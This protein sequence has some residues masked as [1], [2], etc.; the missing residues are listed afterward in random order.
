MRYL[1][2]SGSLS[3]LGG[4]A[5]VR[6]A[7]NGIK[8]LDKKAEFAS[9]HRKRAHKEGICK[10]FIR[11]SQNEEAFKW[12]NVTLDVGGLCNNQR[13]K[14]VWMNLS[15]KYRKPLVYMS[16]SFNKADSK[17][18]KGSKILARGKRSA[19]EV[20]KTGCKAIIA[21]DLSFL[22]IPAEWKGKLYERAFV[23]HKPKKFKKM[24][25]IC[26]KNTDVQVFWKPIAEPKLPIDSFYGT[27]EQNFGLI[28][29]V[30]EVHTA[31]YQAGC[32]AILSGKKPIFYRKGDPRYDRKY[33]DLLDLYG[34]SK[35]QLK[36]SAMKSC[37]MAV[38]VAMK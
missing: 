26:G 2:V 1:F 25:E 28:S 8:A 38:E 33:D 18:L 36:E 13:Y 4:L 11:E 29:S 7:M 23:T 5:M 35:E 6:G 22:V 12:T 37:E 17:F 24:N 9:L 10:N 19:T 30:K 14:Y 3:D 31:R 16:Q 20:R 15:K 27:V 34:M 32:A 21:A